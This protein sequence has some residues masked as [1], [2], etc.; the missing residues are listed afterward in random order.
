MVFRSN[1][2]LNDFERLTK[3]LNFGPEFDKVM[4]DLSSA[5]AGGFAT[6]G[7]SSPAPMH[8]TTRLGVD[9]VRS[10]ESFDLFIDLPG[11]DRADIDVTVEGST[12]TIKGERTFEIADDAQHLHAGRRH[13]SF[14]HTVE[15]AD[16]LDVDAL[17][18]RTENG[19][20]VI[21]VPVIESPEPRKI[22]ISVEG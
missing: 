11:V 14:H 8:R 13:G 22:D 19:V 1:E 16:D 6:T 9:A 2:L 15:L 7:E 3:G 18:A 20:L 5:F 21:S 17:T 12:L 10:V 4:N